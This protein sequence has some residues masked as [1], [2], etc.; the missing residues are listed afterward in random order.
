LEGDQV[1]NDTRTR[2]AKGESDATAQAP[3]E[4]AAE[5]LDADDAK[6]AVDA[7]RG[8]KK[9]VLADEL[10]KLGFGSVYNAKSAAEL[11]RRFEAVAEQNTK[12][13][14]N[15]RVQEARITTLNREIGRNEDNLRRHDEVVGE[16]GD[17]GAALRAGETRQDLVNRIEQQ[18][19]ELASL[20]DT[21]PAKATVPEAEAAPAAEAREPWEKSAREYEAQGMSPTPDAKPMFNQ[22]EALQKQRRDI[23]DKIN[24]LD[25]RYVPSDN[26]SETERRIL[27]SGKLSEL[28]KSRAVR[29]NALGAAILSGKSR[30]FEWGTRDKNP[31]V[32]RLASERNRI[33][34][35]DKAI[36]DRIDSLADHKA[37]VEYALAAGKPVPESVLA[38]IDP[39]NVDSVDKVKT[40][41]T[42][43]TAI[44]NGKEVVADSF[45][46]AA[47]RVADNLATGD[48]GYV[49]SPNGQ[50][51]EVASDRKTAVIVGE[52]RTKQ[53][54]DIAMMEDR[55]AK[56]KYPG[57]REAL[58]QRLAALKSEIMD[59][60]GIP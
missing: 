43:F 32:N 40:I 10:R 34:A 54:R 11:L 26:L 17:A 15:K 39:A 60:A 46:R 5:R 21:A 18:K 16:G 13:N 42:K 23:E 57:E 12:T 52:T 3:H 2:K 9:D 36:A 49:R 14:R 37:W 58:S 27:A 53:Q 55:I 29:E 30:P 1:M 56:A 31:E 48:H 41:A 50:L 28:R 47:Q 59:S 4:I 19:R 6:G 22:R 35:E 7:F 51:H 45:Q 38:E 24:A 20:T 25:N 44:Y 33:I 8:L